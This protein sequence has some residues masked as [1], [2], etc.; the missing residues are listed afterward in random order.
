MTTTTHPM[1]ADELLQMPSDGRRYELVQGELKSMT[2]AGAG[3]GAIII[4][5]AAPLA[6]HVLAH[7]LGEVF[8]AETGF[9]LA[10]NPDTVR[11]PDIAFVAAARIPPGGLPDG[12]FPGAPD[13]AVEVVSPGD[14]LYEVEDKVMAWR[15]AGTRLVWVV[16]PRRRTVTVQDDAGT[17]TVLQ[18]QD[19]LSGG[20]V[21]TGFQVRLSTIFTL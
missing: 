1:T 12:Y 9:I 2:P 5:L 3:H 6:Q 17:V 21:V 7:R 10:R 8:G 11:A 13:L 18:G 20:A 19:E 4:H 14:T 16:N 15:S